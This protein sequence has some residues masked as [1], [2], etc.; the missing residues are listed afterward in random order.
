M[1]YPEPRYEPKEDQGQKGEMSKE[2]NSKITTTV[3][4]ASESSQVKKQVT[5][6]VKS[7]LNTSEKQVKKE[8]LFEDD[9]SKRKYIIPARRREKKESQGKLLN[10]VKH[11]F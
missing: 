6:E 5:S 9:I 2:V 7:F 8:S 11:I 10:Y 4:E 1:G 3:G